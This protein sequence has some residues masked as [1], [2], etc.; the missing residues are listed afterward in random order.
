MA[1]YNIGIYSGY[2]CAFAAASLFHPAENETNWRYMFFS[3]SAPPV[4]LTGLLLFTT[5]DLQWEDRKKKAAIDKQ[6]EQ[7]I[8]PDDTLETPLITE[9]STDSSANLNVNMISPTSSEASLPEPSP[10]PSP[11][12]PPPTSIVVDCFRVLLTTPALLTLCIASAIRTGS[13]VVWGYCTEQFFENERSLTPNQIS[14]WMS[15]TP[16]VF[17]SAGALLGGAI[18]DWLFRKYGPKYRIALLV[19]AQLLAAPCAWAA[20]LLSYP[21]AFLMY[22]LYL[23]IGETYVGTCYAVLM[24]LTP[25]RF[26]AFIVAVYVF[27]MSNLGGNMNLLLPPI[28]NALGGSL[29]KGL[30]VLWPGTVALSAVL[31]SIQWRWTKSGQVDVKD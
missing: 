3:F 16:I 11:P 15:W 23:L 17:G 2:G 27:F 1:V 14:A 10:A 8:V 31:Y 22:S 24:D 9:D 29:Y 28:Q 13:G 19:V 20:L 18:S 12:L 26:H 21:Y 5:K 30:L 4:I 7:L 6:K 25:P